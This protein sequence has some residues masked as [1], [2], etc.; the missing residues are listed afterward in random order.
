MIVRRCLCLKCSLVL[1]CNQ[2]KPPFFSHTTIFT[3]S[4]MQGTEPCKELTFTFEGL[5]YI[6]CWN[7]MIKLYE[8]DQRQAIRM[9]KLTHTSM[10]PKPLQRQSV[11]LLCQVFNE[12]TSAALG[13]LKNVVSPQEW[14]IIFVKVISEWFT[15]MNVKCVFA[16]VKR[17]DELRQTWTIDCKCFK[18]L[19]VFCDLIATCTWTRKLIRFTGNAPITITRENFEAIERLLSNQDVSFVP[20][21]LFIFHTT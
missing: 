16:Q 2:M 10:C 18:K 1:S 14:T 5:N 15:M 19:K 8:V 17:R 3:S 20:L 11:P 9:T 7:N 13:S 6:A 4:K 21:R 12:K